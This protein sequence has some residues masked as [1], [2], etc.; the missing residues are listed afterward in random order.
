MTTDSSA[1]TQRGSTIAFAGV[2]KTYPEATHASVHDVSFT[3]EPGQF[4]VLLGP[5]GCGK[6][7]LLKM[8]NRLIEP[9]TG[10]IAINGQD[11]HTLPI[12]DLRRSIG[13]VIQQVGLFPHMRIETN[14]AIVPSLLG[15]D[16]A[17]ISARID[18]LLTLVGLPPNDYRRRYPAQ[19]SGGEQQRV[20]LARALA[21]DPGTMLMDEPFGALDAITRT[22]LQSELMQIHRQLGKTILFVTHDID[23]AFRLADRIVVMRAGNL[24][25]IGTPLE[26]VQQ[27]A[28]AF[29]RDLV[30][31]D[32]V[33]RRLS[34]IRVGDVMVPS[35]SP[36]TGPHVPLES[37]LRQVLGI[38]IEHGADSLAVQ[39][40]DGAVIG[41]IGLD[42]IRHA[43]QP[44]GLDASP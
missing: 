36:G 5:S 44:I 29:V 11:S 31:A 32:D 35:T 26:I 6:T 2:G 24:V 7:T 27:P 1:P 41:T 17:R 14:I 34:L 16:K 22:R 13:Y 25:Q 23:E 43:S 28:D 9:S 10:T 12:Q 20:G 19:L 38:L 21:G 8:V 4:L 30:G 40:E 39:N 42:Q 37:D 33:L 18:D 15:W 3:I